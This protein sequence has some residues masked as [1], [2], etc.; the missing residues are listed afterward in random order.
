MRTRMEVIIVMIV[1][2]VHILPVIQTPIPTAI[3][4]PIQAIAQVFL[5]VILRLN[6]ILQEDQPAAELQAI[7][8]RAVQ[9]LRAIA[10]RAVQIVIAV[11]AHPILA[12]QVALPV[13]T[14]LQV[15]QVPRA[16][17]VLQAHQVRHPGHT[18]LHL[19]E[20]VQAVDHARL[21]AHQAAEDKNTFQT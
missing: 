11:Q 18:V 12:V 1:V 16:L 7:V 17:T 2:P 9:A 14:V 8:V 21:A 20:A 5:Q 4:G 10:V 19:Q 15:H 13:H 6:Q 3:A